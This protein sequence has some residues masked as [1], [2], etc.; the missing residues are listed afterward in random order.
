MQEEKNEHQ[1]KIEFGI[2]KIDIL[3]KSLDPSRLPLNSPK[4]TVYSFNVGVE[5]EI[6]KENKSIFVIISDLISVNE[7]QVDLGELT[8]RMEF[9]IIN[10]DELYNPGT[11][12]FNMPIHI[13]GNFISLSLSTHRGILFTLAMGTP[14]SDIIFPLMD[15]GMVAQG[16]FNQESTP[17]T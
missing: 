16:I 9:N 3:N 17:K 11:N 1:A 7:P 12:A 4:P 10:F 5:F 8:S 2:R 14:I 6:N 13:L 15:P